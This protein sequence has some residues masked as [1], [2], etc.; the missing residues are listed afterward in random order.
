MN[1]G[2][3]SR[4]RELALRLEPVIAHLFA[5]PGRCKPLRRIGSTAQDPGDSRHRRAS[6]HTRPRAQRVERSPLAAWLAPLSGLTKLHTTSLTWM[7][8]N[9]TKLRQVTFI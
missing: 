4:R 5:N 9:L 2:E 1:E 6:G 8:Q 3:P 7:R